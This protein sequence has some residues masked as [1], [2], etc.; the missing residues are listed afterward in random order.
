M[1]QITLKPKTKRGRRKLNKVESKDI[2]QIKHFDSENV[3]CSTVSYDREVILTNNTNQ[4]FSIFFTNKEANRTLNISL[5]G[6]PRA[7]WKD[8]GNMPP[9]GQAHITISSTIIF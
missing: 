7:G 1:E 3:P 4:V 8:T 6:E 5:G 9:G 2:E